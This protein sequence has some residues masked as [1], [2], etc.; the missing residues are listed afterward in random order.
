MKRWLL[1][2]LLLAL[3]LSACRSASPTLCL[4]LTC[5]LVP[6]EP[7]VVIQL[8]AVPPSSQTTPALSWSEDHNT[9]TLT[10]ARQA[11]FTLRLPSPQGEN[12]LSLRW[13]GNQFTL[14]TRSP[15]SRMGELRQGTFPRSRVPLLTLTLPAS[16]LSGAFLTL[17]WGCETMTYSLPL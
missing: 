9:L 13:R 1:P 17:S 15:D 2:V 7:S 11:S 6:G 4:S 12:V 8:A 16:C 10:V 5:P 14:W 3:L